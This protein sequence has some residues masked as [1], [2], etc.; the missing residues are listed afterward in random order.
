MYSMIFSAESGDREFK[1]EGP[2]QLIWAMGRLDHKN[3]PAFHDFY[4]RGS[5]SVE[6]GRKEPYNTCFSFTRTNKELRYVTYKQENMKAINNN[7]FYIPPLYSPTIKISK[8][9]TCLKHSFDAV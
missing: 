6:L 8:S 3:E 5:L 9:L 1:E 4:P 7:M 2:S